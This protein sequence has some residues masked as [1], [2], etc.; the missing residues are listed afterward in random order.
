VTRRVYVDDAPIARL[1]AVPEPPTGSEDGDLDVDR[2]LALITRSFAERIGAETALLV[3]SDDDGGS[4]VPRA[5]WGLREGAKAGPVRRGEGAAGRVLEGGPAVAD[6]LDPSDPF[7][8]REG[9]GPR[10]PCTV[11]AAAVRG[12]T[13]TTGAL[14]AG[15]AR[16]PRAE[17]GL[18]RWTAES[19]AAVAAVCL[20]GS[21]LLS[22]LADS[23]R[24]DRLTGCLTHEALR[25]AMQSEIGRTE[26]HGHAL[27]CC[28]VELDGFEGAGEERSDPPGRRALG[29]VASALRKYLRAS[30]IVARYDG[31]TFVVVLPET[32]RGSALQLAL[33]LRDDI[34]QATEAGTGQ[35]VETSMGIGE[36]TPGCSTDTLLRRAGHGLRIAK[37]A[38]GA[39]IAAPSALE[40][41]GGE[42][43]KRSRTSSRA[44]RSTDGPRPLLAIRRNLQRKDRDR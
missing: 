15:L 17:R 7:V 20:E 28:F 36:W 9:C 27:T 4:A 44:Q 34:R 14:Y 19:Y 40:T 22:A 31:K 35:A 32:A 43:R 16:R 18:L 5:S 33:R 8:I 13:G 1:R 42:P 11:V 23:V 26:R 6:A 2:R 12:P 21:G 25:E 24:R 30:D 3:V 37:E 10:Q 39:V 29:G 41:P 38:G